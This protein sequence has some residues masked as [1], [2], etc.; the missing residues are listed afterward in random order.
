M[1]KNV[2]STESFVKPLSAAIAL[3]LLLASGAAAQDATPPA[4]TDDDAAATEKQDRVTWALDG[5][6]D[7]AVLL[8]TIGRRLRL[9]FMYD[10]AQIQP[11]GQV[12]IKPNQPDS[13]VHLDEL[14]GMLEK[15][16]QLKGLSMVRREDWVFVIPADRLPLFE[17]LLQPGQLPPA[18]IGDTG[19]NQ[20][21]RLAHADARDVHEVLTPFLSEFGQCMPLPNQKMVILIENKKRIEVLRQLIKLI[22]VPPKKIATRIV[23]LRFTRAPDIAYKLSNYLQA[24]SQPRERILPVRVV[25]PTTVRLQFTPKKFQPEVQPFIEVDERTNRLFLY[26]K[27]EDLDALENLVLEL[28]VPP[29]E[30]QEVKAYPLTYISAA[31]ALVSLQEL[32]LADTGA[33]VARTPTTRRTTTRTRTPTRTTQEVGGSGAAARITVLEATNTLIIRATPEEHDRIAAFLKVADIDQIDQQRIRVYPIERRLAKDVADYLKSVFQS[34]SIDP[35][36]RAPVPGVEGAPVIVAIE[37][38][39]AVVANATPAQH[40]QIR[41]LIDAID[42]TQPQVLLECVFVEVTDDD[43]SDLGLELETRTPWGSNKNFFGS[44]AFEMSARDALT[45]LRT[46]SSAAPGATLAFLNDDVV[47]VLLHAVQEN[48]HSRI[49]SRPRVLTENNK[50]GKIEAKDLEPKVI[51]E[52]L[53]NVTTRRFDGYEEAGTFLEI[54]PRISEGDFLALKI[55][56]EVSTFTGPAVDIGVPPP[57]AERMIETEIVVPDQRTIVIGGLTGTRNL[58]NIDKVPLLGDIPWI[59]AL[60]RRTV[61]NKRDTTIYLFVKASILRETT[62]QDLY[63][64]TEEAR[65]SIPAELEEIAPDLTDEAILKEIGRLRAL[66]KR[67]A[68]EKARLEQER[69]IEDGGD[70]DTRTYE[71]G[72]AI[73]IDLTPKALKPEEVP[74]TNVPAEVPEAPEEPATDTPV[75]EEPIKDTPA[76]EE[77]VEETPSEKP[78]RSPLPSGP[79]IVPPAR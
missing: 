41:G 30:L 51:V 24:L 79:I 72:E 71:A 57:Q 26:G 46:L 35:R 58:E 74:T 54:T 23:S 16:L 78:R 32:G 63:D 5:P 20:M 2:F 76:T 47:N 8:T 9:K 67:R 49:M 38:I 62:F 3:F 19:A 27:T 21:I 61:I 10:E 37:D 50:I 18:E 75:M 25:S 68:A 65:G 44:T 4:P 29:I 53:D 28:D 12:V 36:T 33:P 34:D 43:D 39:N 6:T 48:D 22:D 59:G 70:T 31:N 7:I 66:R 73:K 14:Y 17:D 40:Q 11:F 45:G 56:T 60:F 55:K 1:H 69:N 77:P 15:A 42:A 52:T 13:T 64:E